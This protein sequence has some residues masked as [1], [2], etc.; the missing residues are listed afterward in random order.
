[1]V[2][3]LQID[4]SWEYRRVQHVMPSIEDFPAQ[5][6]SLRQDALYATTFAPPYKNG[7][8][9]LSS[10]QLSRHNCRKHN[11]LQ[12]SYCPYTHTIHLGLL[13]CLC[14]LHEHIFDDTL[15][16]NDCNEDNNDTDDSPS[17]LIAKPDSRRV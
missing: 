13:S 4:V 2:L 5:A 7:W 17:H 10:Q 6:C 12:T 16:T 9:E 15:F 14:F 11:K 1:M 3:D 8:G